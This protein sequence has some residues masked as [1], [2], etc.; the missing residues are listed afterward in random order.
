MTDHDGQMVMETFIVIVS[1]GPKCPF[2]NSQLLDRRDKLI[3]P[4]VLN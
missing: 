2:G 3:P 4:Y 1:E